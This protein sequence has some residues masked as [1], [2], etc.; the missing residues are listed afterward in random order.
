MYINFNE[1]IQLNLNHILIFRQTH[2]AT[3]QNN[4]HAISK[5]ASNNR[6]HEL[7]GQIDQ[8]LLNL[9]Q[10]GYKIACK[11]LFLTTSSNL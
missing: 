7:N 4:L 2:F 9:S 3:N 8:H 5:N 11:E 1:R 6:F 10:N